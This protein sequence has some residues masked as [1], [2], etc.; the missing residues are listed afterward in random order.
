MSQVVTSLRVMQRME[1]LATQLYR[2][3]LQ[4]FRGHEIADRLRAAAANEQEHVD[5][6][7][8]RIEE[9]GR[10]PSRAG[11]FYQMAGTLLG[12]ATTLLGKVFLLKVDL[13]IERRAVRD[14]GA[15]L[16]NVGFDEKSVALI[17][18]IVADEKKHIETWDNSIQ[19]L[20]GRR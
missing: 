16:Q 7:T 8:E 18:K 20:K 14:Y 2:T 1:R 13:F 17:T 12:F 4:A 10:T 3:Q 11:I 15:F 6:L 9:L 19:I 5:T